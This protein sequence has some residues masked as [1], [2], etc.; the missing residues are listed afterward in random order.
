MQR[1]ALVW[2]QHLRT[3]VWLSLRI[4]RRRWHR[5]GSL[6][7]KVGVLGA[8]LAVFA[9]CLSF[10]LALGLGAALLPE[11]EPDTV[12][13]T[14]AGLI[15]VF[16]LLRVMDALGRLQ[17]GDGLP[18]DNLLHLPFSLHQVFLLNF[19]LS[20]LGLSTFIFVPAFVG[21][22]IAC[23]IALDVRNFVLIPASLSLVLCV[24]AVIY[25]VQGWITS[26][27]AT[28]RRRVLI[29]Y[30]VFTMLVVL[31]QASYILYLTQ[32]VWSEPEATEATATSLEPD[33]EG[34]ALEEADQGTRV[35]TSEWLLRGWVAHGSEYGRHRFPWPSLIGM[36]GLLMITFVSLRRSYRAT[37]ARYRHGQTANAPPRAGAEQQARRMRARKARASPVA[38]IAYIMLKHWFRSVRGVMECLPMFAVLALVGF[39]SFRNP[40]ESDPYTLPLAV[41][42]IMSMFCVPMELAG[43]LF[44][45]D[46]RGFRVYRFAGVPGRTLLLGKYL[47]LL[48]PFILLAG[49]MLAVSAVLKSMPPTHILGTILQGGIIFFA[50]CT[51]GGAFSIGSPYAVSPTSMTRRGSLGA[52]FLMLLAR[53][54][55]TALLISIAW[56]A[57][58]AERGLAE[59]GHAVPVYL[60]VSMIEFGLSVVAF[61]ALLGR[62][63]R[64]LVERSDQILDAVSVTD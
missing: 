12:M 33:Y 11:A 38:A 57:L 56:P 51:I 61:R 9:A 64:A 46:G 54:A 28:K 3:V 2:T 52:A 22:S 58:A 39:F 44:G 27:M 59:D 15:A 18:L 4:W 6:N 21:L 35:G 17:Q 60:V 31:M 7:R 63:A 8:G 53:L 25:Q 24:A 50:C 14:W 55:V 62:S 19:A 10:L 42:G 48:P 32:G 20:Q 16:M 23:T 5:Q 13:L 30:L 34:V 47:A 41:I 49:A 37:L 36:A 45:F 29:G 40:G 1:E 26:A 43:N